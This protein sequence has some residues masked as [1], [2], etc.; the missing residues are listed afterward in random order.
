L[1]VYGGTPEASRTVAKEPIEVSDVLYRFT[2]E[3]DPSW[4]ID[5]NWQFGIPQGLGGT[6]DG[7]PDP[8]AGCTG[9][10]VY[11]VNLAGDYS[12]AVGGP[13]YLTAGPFDCTGFNKVTLCYARWLNSDTKPYISNTVEASANGTDWTIIWDP[14]ETSLADGE[15]QAIE[16]DISQVADGQASVYIRWGYAISYGGAY[17]CS[18]WNIDDIELKGMPAK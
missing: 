6:D 11:G 1:G 15:W 3:T 10:N 5:D 4:M 12:I 14:M 8:A 18:G 2:L 7:N 13:Y 17:A 16:H 9:N